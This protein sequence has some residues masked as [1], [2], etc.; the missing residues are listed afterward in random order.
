MCGPDTGSAAKGVKFV[1]PISDQSY[2]QFG[3]LMALR[4]KHV[5]LHMA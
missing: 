5:K 1:L 3:A 4:R 2:R